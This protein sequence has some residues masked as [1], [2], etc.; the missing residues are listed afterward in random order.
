[1]L[2]KN[3]LKLVNPINFG[4]IKD[5]N[6]LIVILRSFSEQN[7]IE[8]YLVFNEGK[9]NAIERFNETLGEMIQ[10]HITTNQTT[11]YIDVLQKILH[12]YNNRYH[13]SIKMTPF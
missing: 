9:A 10:K 5:Q 12:E 6:S 7:N 4:L 3:C 11:K 2:L 8:L 13:T 1:M